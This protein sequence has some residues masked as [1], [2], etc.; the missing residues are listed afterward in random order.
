MN[1]EEQR[2]PISMTPDFYRKYY[3]AHNFMRDLFVQECYW[4]DADKVTDWHIQTW[5]NYGL[6]MP[7]RETGFGKV[8]YQ[9]VDET[10]LKFRK[11]AGEYQLASKAHA[12]NK[13]VGL[14]WSNT[15]TI[16]KT[17]MRV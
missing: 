6:G 13:D 9:M 16:I 3:K 1:V 12:L 5:I 15:K 2:E 8:W 14:W 4:L 7:L 11:E 17:F 10:R